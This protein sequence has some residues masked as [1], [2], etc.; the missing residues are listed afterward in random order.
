MGEMPSSQRVELPD[1][2]RLL[3]VHA[4][5]TR[6][7]GMGLGAHVPAEYVAAAV[8]GCDAEVVCAG[9]THRPYDAVVDG[10]RVVNLGSVSNPH[11]PDLRA[12]YAVVEATAHGCTVEHRRVDY[13]REAVIGL[14]ERRRHPGRAW[15]VAHLRGEHA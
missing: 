11:P 13:D 7:D 14:L 9:H 5:P 1:G 2:S 8:A 3:G 15:I 10:T 4:D 6:D 12:S